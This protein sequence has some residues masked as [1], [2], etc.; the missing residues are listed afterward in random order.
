MQTSLKDVAEPY[1]GKVEEGS[2]TLPESTLLM[3]LPAFSDQIATIYT[4][5]ESND[6]VGRVKKE[7]IPSLLLYELKRYHSFHETLVTA[8]N[9]AVTIVNHESEILAINHR[10]EELYHL[11]NENVKKKPLQ[12]F[13][14]EDALVLWSVLRDKQPVMNQYNQ[15]KQGLHVIVNTVPVFL[16]VECIGGISIERDITDV[17]KLNEKLSSTTASLHDLNGQVADEPFQKIIGRSKPI[18]QAIDMARK[19]AK[20]EANLLLTGESGVGKE[21]FAEGVHQ[22]SNRNKEPFVAINCGAIPSA[23]FESELFGYVPGAFTGAVKGGKKGKLDVAKGGT[24]FLDEVAEMPLELQVKLLRVLQERVFYR[25]GDHKPI[26]LDVRII[27]ATNRHL[28][29]M[30][31]EGT[32]REDLYY[33][34]HVI[35]I[36]VPPLRERLDDLPELMQRFAQEFAIR[37]DKVVPTFDPE[38]MYMLMNHRWEGNIRQLRNLVE[39]VIIL[40]NDT[41]DRVH[42]YHLPDSFQKQMNHVSS[43]N[44]SR[45]DERSEILAALEKTFGNKSAAAK[46]LGVSRATLYNKL[47][48][49]NL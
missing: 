15:P 30:I 42:W 3:N 21:L 18:T 27:A 41:E 39:R 1:T 19:V 31:Q 24:L 23:L 5:N 25:V 49:Y 28:E 34:L 2:W 13:F 22:A 29:E 35:Q 10:S 44:Y 6:V 40:T 8:M 11:N 7:L 48:H 38:V 47:K 32:F 36:H 16:G 9:D 17:V 37:Y 26:P 4:V 43:A 46:L 45:N 14:E 20:T 12:Q 33:R